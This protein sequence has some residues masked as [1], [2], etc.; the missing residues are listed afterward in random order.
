MA[1]NY[2]V[3]AKNWDRLVK[4]SNRKRV[5]EMTLECLSLREAL[6]ILSAGG[7]EVEAY[8]FTNQTCPSCGER[9]ART[10]VFYAT[11]IS[12]WDCKLY[13]NGLSISTGEA[14][15]RAAD[16]TEAN[17]KKI[18]APNIRANVILALLAQSNGCVVE[19]MRLQLTSGD[20]RTQRVALERLRQLAAR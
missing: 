12:C 19:E 10:S 8:Q 20:S 5:S 4:L 2:M 17:F 16:R 11:C 15:M 3:V 14:W 1:R 13:P 9:M 18:G 6:R 7:P